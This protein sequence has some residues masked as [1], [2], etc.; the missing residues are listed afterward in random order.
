MHVQQK[1]NKNNTIFVSSSVWV[2]KVKL[3]D[4][5]EIFHL[6]LNWQEISVQVFNLFQNNPTKFCNRITESYTQ[7]SEKI[8]NYAFKLDPK[9][10]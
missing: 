4:I 2:L 9:C 8:I 6:E 1:F 7:P 5:K 10:M 3:S